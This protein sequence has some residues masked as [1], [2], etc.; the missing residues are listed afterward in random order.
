M[1][2]V[3][4]GQSKEEGER[5]GREGAA[6]RS[7]GRVQLS[8]RHLRAPVP[9]AVTAGRPGCPEVASERTHR[10]WDRRYPPSAPH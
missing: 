1:A 9:I 6:R 2:G 3:G 5:A 4:G 8:S 7:S 10:Q